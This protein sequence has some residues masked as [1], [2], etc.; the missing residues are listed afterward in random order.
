MEEGP[1]NFK[2]CKRHLVLTQ[3]EWI[4]MSVTM[5]WD[6]K[7]AYR[8]IGQDKKQGSYLGH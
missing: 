6:N 3:W 1:L 4:L 8:N 7:T 2:R 5:P